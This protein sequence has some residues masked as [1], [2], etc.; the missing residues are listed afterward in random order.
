MRLY[1]EPYPSPGRLVEAARRSTALYSGGFMRASRRW[2]RSAVAAAVVGGL[3]GIGTPALAAGAA[4]P[5]VPPSV[6]ITSHDAAITEFGQVSVSATTPAAGTDYP[7]S[8]GITLNGT[9]V[10]Q[11]VDGHVTAALP[12]D[13]P[14]GSNDVHVVY[15][16]HRGNVRGH[17]LSGG[18]DDDRPGACPLQCPSP[19]GR[20][21]R[22]VHCGD[23]LAGR[24]EG[25]R[26][27]LRHHQ[28]HAGPLPRT[29]RVGRQQQI[30]ATGSMTSRWISWSTAA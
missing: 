4:S 6:T 10:S 18:H 20:L 1:A 25:K 5:A 28:R 8:V 26:P 15:R 12:C 11:D 29:P 17:R 14:T 9:L 2:T 19:G 21:H 13:E 7:V 23:R 30:G 3:L 22:S 16:L 27:P 24:L